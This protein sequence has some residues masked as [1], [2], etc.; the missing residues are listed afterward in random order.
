VQALV[1]TGALTGERG[2]CRLARP[3]PGIQ[4]PATVQAV[5]AA[6]IDR[7]RPEDKTLLQTA[8]VIGKDVPL[9]LL[10]EMVEPTAGGLDAAI[11]RLQNAEFLY[12]ASL[13][14][15]PEYTF[16][17]ALT[18]DVA[19]SSLLQDR[20]RALHG[21]VVATIERLHPDRLTEHVERLAH[22]AFRGDLW[23][24]AV[25]YLRQA[26]AKALTRSANRE[27]A[28]YLEQALT[29]LAHLPETRKTLEQAIDVRFNLRDAFVPLAEFN[30]IAAYLREAEAL[31]TALDDQRRLGWVSAYIGAIHMIASGHVTDMRTAIQRVEAIG[32]TLGDKALQVAAQHYRVQIDYLAGDY[33]GT[34]NTCRRLMQFLQ[35]DD[36]R[37]RFGLVQSPAVLSRAFLA[38][39]LAEGGVFDEGEAHGQ[40]AIRI[41]EVLDHPF[42]L[43]EACV[44]LA[45]VHSVRGDLN[46]A[47]R[48]AERAVALSRDW[49]LTTFAPNAMATLGQV[50]AGLGRVEEGLPWL[51]QALAGHDSAGIGY[52]HAVSLVQA[53]EAYRLAG[54]VED[55]RACANRAL[56]LTRE[57]GERGHEAWALRLLGEIAAHADPPDLES[58]QQHYSQALTRATE[59]S[60]RP[61]AAHCHLGLSRVL[62]TTGHQVKAAEHLTIA[63]AMYREM[64]MGFWLE[65]AEAELASPLGIHPDAGLIT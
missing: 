40:D 43:V 28:A 26:G 63:A 33:R 30:R 22:H 53:G 32:E 54:H 12:E 49:T 55:A 36:I 21:R 62:H 19:Y 52:F 14:P 5:L 57:R 37:D 24:K 35:G 29:A 34:E 25:T 58:A 64:D 9:A 4:V 3:L 42:T 59:L 45:Y 16:K 17:H 50:Y 47:I 7:L 27:A 48:P 39:A 44:G 15:D 1:E 11:E 10:R 18:H 65:K 56:T 41:A 8:S 46:G 61:L 38:R 60:M 23:E 13:F 31:A 51:Q 6:R 20:R 2:A